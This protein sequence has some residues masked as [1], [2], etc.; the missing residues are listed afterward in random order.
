M[1][2][3]APHIVPLSRQAVTIVKMLREITGDGLYLFP[4]NRT[5]TRPISEN[6]LNAA[7]RRLGYAPTT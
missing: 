4:S 1:K 7:L 5:V 6:T 2:M 3:K